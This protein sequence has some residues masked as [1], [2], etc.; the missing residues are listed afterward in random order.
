M[1]NVVYQQ[2]I[3]YTTVVLRCVA[4]GQELSLSKHACTLKYDAVD[5][6]DTPNE[7]I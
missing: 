3:V 1:F 6:H 7:S 2:C 4:T 5:K